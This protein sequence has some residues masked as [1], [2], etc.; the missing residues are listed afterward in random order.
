MAVSLEPTSVGGAVRGGLSEEKDLHCQTREKWARKS[1]HTGVCTWNGCWRISADRYLGELMPTCKLCH[2]WKVPDWVLFPIVILKLLYDEFLYEDT[3][4][5]R[6]LSDL[7]MIRPTENPNRETCGLCLSRQDW[8]LSMPLVC[9]LPFPG[10]LLPHFGRYLE[11][12]RCAR[13]PRLDPGSGE[14]QFNTQ[15]HIGRTVE[16]K[17]KL[18][19]IFTSVY[20]LGPHG[21]VRAL[22]FTLMN[23]SGKLKKKNKRKNNPAMF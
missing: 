4:Q 15:V 7:P 21:W 17:L 1:S 14:Q 8:A 10:S 3:T 2:S 22:R 13:V 16:I 6:E 18:R 5:S 20:C 23:P 9:N 12:L 11:E 19:F